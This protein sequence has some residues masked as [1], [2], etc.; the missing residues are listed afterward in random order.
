M[1]ETIVNLLR[2]P[3]DRMI[4]FDQYVEIISANQNIGSLPFITV[5]GINTYDTSE[6]ALSSFRWNYIYETNANQINPLIYN[7]FQ[8]EEDEIVIVLGLFR[9]LYVRDRNGNLM[10]K[11]ICSFTNGEW[12]IEVI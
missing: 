4:V 7:L 11:I 3:I 1:E 6:G 2:I 9:N 5:A 12:N 10:G 8:V